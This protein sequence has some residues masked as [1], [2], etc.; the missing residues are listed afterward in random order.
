MSVQAQTYLSLNE[1]Y[2]SSK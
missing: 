1:N 2:H